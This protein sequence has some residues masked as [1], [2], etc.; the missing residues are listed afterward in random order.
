MSVTAFVLLMIYHT[1]IMLFAG[2][3]IGQEIE[4]R[5]INRNKNETNR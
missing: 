1:S 5:R 4:K 3:T 2:Y